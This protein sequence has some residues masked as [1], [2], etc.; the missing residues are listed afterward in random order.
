MPN[1]H[2]SSRDGANIPFILFCLFMAF[3]VQS[4]HAQ[5]SYPATGDAL[6]HG[7]TI[8][9]GPGI[10][11][12]V[13]TVLGRK[14]LPSNTSGWANV[15]V[16]Y[17]TLSSNTSGSENTAVGFNALTFNTG[18]TGYSGNNNTAIGYNSLSANTLGQANA[19]LGSCAM[20]WM[21]SGNYNTACG[22]AALESNS[23]GNGNVAVG[24]GAMQYASGNSN[25]AVG[26]QSLLSGS[27]ASNIVAVGDSAL[28]N[29]TASFNT[30]VGSKSLVSTTSGAYN[31][32]L[33]YQSL[34]TNTTGYAN[35]AS[36]YEALYSNQTGAN[37]AA[38]GMD[39]LFLNTGNNNTATGAYTLYYNTSG[40]SNTAYGLEAMLNNTTGS[41]NTG[42]GTLAGPTTGNLT[43][44]TAIGY[45]AG[46]SASN[47]VV[48]GNSSVTSIGGYAGWTNF[49]DGR[50]K[51]NINRNVPGLAFINKLTPITYTLDI[52]G[53]EAMRQKTTPAAK[54]PGGTTHPHASDDPA[55]KQAIKEKS[56]VVYTGFVAQD[57]DKAAQSVGYNFSGVDKPKDDQQSFYGLRYSDFVVPLTRAVQEL[58]AENDSLKQVNAQ[59]SQRLDQIEQL[60]GL[61][62]VAAQNSST[63]M[64]S[65]ARLFQNIPNPFNQATLINYYL[66]PNTGTALLQIT[67]ITGET[68]KSIVL[69]GT[70]AGQVSIG[71]AQLSAGTYMYS[72]V[73]DGNLIDTKTM[74]LVK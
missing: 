30:A 53:I 72:L 2:T 7:L 63:V 45:D 16:G 12:T 73:V 33:G 42:V 24:N 32:A 55:M 22:T 20:L 14:A 15:A 17:Y 46:V 6:I 65:S 69:T 11:D 54:T 51:K 21:T 58:S 38:Y 70:G 18:G 64:L 27:S 62:T 61:K 9:A 34:Y 4:A 26:Y 43:N 74:I 68:I 56:A 19:A 59:L 39:A 52:D 44:T 40:I 35:M 41:Y 60:L 5:N 29:N 67:G 3:T 71:T 66:P 8:G 23:T 1:L 48:I 50:F 37:N 47:S 28:L 31:T 13:N 25:V 57:V 36:G 10:Y 49:S